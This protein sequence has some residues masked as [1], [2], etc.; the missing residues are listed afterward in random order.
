[1]SAIPGITKKTEPPAALSNRND[2]LPKILAGFVMAER[3]DRVIERKHPVDER[4]SR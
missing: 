4:L 2:D 1:V 3:F